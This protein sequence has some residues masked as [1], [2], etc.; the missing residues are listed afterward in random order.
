MPCPRPSHHM[1]IGQT[2]HMRRDIGQTMNRSNRTHAAG[3]C[4]NNELVKQDTSGRKLVKQWIGQTGYIRPD[5]GQTMN[6]SNRTHAA[7]HW[8]NNELVKQDTS[9]RT[10]VKQ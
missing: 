4:S 8:S 10:L 9:G 1:E 5:I 7:G 3:H 2:G 6:W